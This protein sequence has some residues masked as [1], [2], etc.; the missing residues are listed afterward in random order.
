MLLLSNI[1]LVSLLS[2][3]QC[4]A[5]ATHRPSFQEAMSKYSDVSYL[6]TSPHKKPGQVL[7]F[8]F[9]ELPAGVENT[10]TIRLSYMFN[11]VGIKVPG[12]RASLYTL[13]DQ[14]GNNYCL[15]VDELES[16]LTSI[17][18][19]PDHTIDKGAGQP[20]DFNILE[21]KPAIFLALFG[22]EAHSDIYNGSRYTSPDTSYWNRATHITS[23]TLPGPGAPFYPDGDPDPNPTHI[24][25]APSP[26]TPQNWQPSA[27]DLQQRYAKI[28]Q[29]YYTLKQQYD[30]PTYDEYMRQTQQYTQGLRLYNQQ[31]SR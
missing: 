10:C 13:P 1:L 9:N 5:Q 6:E 7:Q 8:I 12:N 25:Q 14:R 29:L 2:V 20:M 26:D 19:R 18:G 17:W 11:G 24:S 27:Q 31:H 30:K 21:G 16:Y 23:W 15:R 4:L 28:W 3:S 22:T